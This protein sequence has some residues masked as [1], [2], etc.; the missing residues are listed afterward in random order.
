MVPISCACLKVIIKIYQIID[1]KNNIEE[2]RHNNVGNPT[3]NQF[4][5][6]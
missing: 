3:T 5:Y 6:R 2:V 1:S 4:S